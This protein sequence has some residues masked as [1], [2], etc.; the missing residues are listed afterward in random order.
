MV[1]GGYEP[2][3]NDSFPFVSLETFLNMATVSSYALFFTMPFVIFRVMDAKVRKTKT[4][5]V[6]L[7]NGFL[8]TMQ[9]MVLA[10]LFLLAISIAM[11]IPKGMLWP[12]LAVVLLSTVVTLVL[13]A[14]TCSTEFYTMEVST[15]SELA[16]R[17]KAFMPVSLFE[18]YREDSGLD[19]SATAPLRDTSDFTQIPFDVGRKHQ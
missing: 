4:R 7:Y 15:V 18:D 13:T 5:S 11:F 2:A 6:H 16:K 9:H 14:V 3:V 10:L 12:A 17:W 1:I 8:S 19:G